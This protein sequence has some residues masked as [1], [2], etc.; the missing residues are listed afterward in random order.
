MTAAIIEEAQQAGGAESLLLPQQELS[1]DPIE[2]EG[3]QHDDDMFRSPRQRRRQRRLYVFTSLF[4]ILLIVAIVSIVFGTSRSNEKRQA[5]ESGYEGGG[6]VSSPSPSCPGNT[7]LFSIRHESPNNAPNENLNDTLTTHFTWALHEVCSGKVVLKCQPCPS[8]SIVVDRPGGH[9]VDVKLHK[10]QH[11]NQLQHGDDVNR[12][13]LAP[14]NEYALE[15]RPTYS[16][17]VCCGFS[18]PTTLVATYD[19]INNIRIDGWS[20]LQKE[21]TKHDLCHGLDTRECQPVVGCEY[22]STRG[23]CHPLYYVGGG[24]KW[25][26]HFGEQLVPCSRSKDDD[27]RAVIIANT[28]P[29]TTRHHHLNPS[30]IQR[31]NFQPCPRRDRQLQHRPRKVQL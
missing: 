24:K 30:Q 20:A 8:S 6:D 9:T 7:K 28:A 31:R 21:T 13:C 15:I 26:V 5:E 18:D 23:I 14:D 1:D 22:D 2:Q 19:D 25:T 27:E 4:L 3:E 11:Q 16:S 29:P 10:K 12:K 17:T